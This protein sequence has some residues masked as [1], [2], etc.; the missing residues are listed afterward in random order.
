MKSEEDQERKGRAIRKILESQ[1]FRVIC[2][3]LALQSVLCDSTLQY[4]DVMEVYFIGS[5][6]DQGT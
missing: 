4:T 1:E 2:S 5:N 3:Q 6:I